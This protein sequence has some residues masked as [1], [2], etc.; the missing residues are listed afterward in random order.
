MW[1]QRSHLQNPPPADGYWVHAEDGNRWAALHV[2]RQLTEQ[3]P[4]ALVGAAIQDQLLR[5]LRRTD[6]SGVRWSTVELVW[7]D[8][9]GGDI[10]TGI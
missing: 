1:F 4:P 2:T 6:Q 9:Y 10:E 8:E 3:S 5:E 7:R